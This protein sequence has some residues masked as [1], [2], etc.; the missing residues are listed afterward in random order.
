MGVFT[1]DDWNNLVQRINTLI[2]NPPANTSCSAQPALAQVPA[3]H[4]WSKTDIQKAQNALKAICTTISFSPTPDL[5]R[6]SILDEINTALA[7]GWCN[8]QPTRWCWHVWYSFGCGNNYPPP[9][10]DG[11]GGG[12][13]PTQVAAGTA[14]RTVLDQLNAQAAAKGYPCEPGTEDKWFVVVETE[15]SPC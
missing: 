9:T 10:L 11:G 7:T 15:L 5:W 13:Y 1:R 14:M 6:Q 12:P 2:Q 3:D 4:I 8:C